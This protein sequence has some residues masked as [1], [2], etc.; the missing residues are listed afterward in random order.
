MNSTAASAQVGFWLQT[1]SQAACEIAR[2]VGYDFVIF[3]VEH[4]V[5]DQADLDRLVPFCALLGLDTYVRVGYADRP[6]IQ[7][8]LDTG[9]SGI[10][11]PQIRDLSHAKEVTPFAKYPPLGNRGFGFNRT[12]QFDAVEDPFVEQENSRQQCFAMIETPGAL[13]S[14]AQIAALPWVDGLFIGPGDLS[15]SRGRGVFK[16]ASS[17]FE[18]LRMVANAAQAGSKLFAAAAPNDE[19]RKVAESLKAS[20][21]AVADELSAMSIGFSAMR[22]VK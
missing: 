15:L 2:K 20:F 10:I 1:S 22:G 11:L 4:G 9:A 13:D 21:V 14:A 16:G 8:A 12:M 17:D 7:S 19:Y 5:F 6:R 18:E 3:D